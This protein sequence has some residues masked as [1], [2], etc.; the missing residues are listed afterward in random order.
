MEG[1]SEDIE[2]SVAIEF[3]PGNIPSNTILFNKI[4]PSTLGT[5]LAIQEH[6][7]FVQS[8][9]WNINPF[10]QFGVELGKKVAKEIEDEFNNNSNNSFDSS[11]NTLIKRS[12]K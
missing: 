9:I 7:V 6:K 3:F 8:V 10:D 4:T 11:T 12:K 5:Y 1:N 2:E